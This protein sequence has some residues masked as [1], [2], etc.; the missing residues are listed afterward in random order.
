MDLK[1]QLVIWKK[2]E[3]L[4]DNIAWTPKLQCQLVEEGIL[5]ARMVADIH[6]SM[7]VYKG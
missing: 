3:Y 6:V 5:T 4:V 2:A 7:L 1:E